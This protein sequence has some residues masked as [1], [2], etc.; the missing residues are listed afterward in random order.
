MR[1]N[2]LF[3][4]ALDEEINA[5]LKSR[6]D[7]LAWH[8]LGEPTE[9]N[10]V[11]MWWGDTGNIVIRTSGKRRG[12]FFWRSRGQYG[13]ALSLIMTA[14]NLNRSEAVRFA[15]HWLEQRA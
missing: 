10:S 8:L 12:Q 15:I 13:D 1:S 11:E 6:I 7:E 9:L 2:F 4:A 14:R 3:T 5:R